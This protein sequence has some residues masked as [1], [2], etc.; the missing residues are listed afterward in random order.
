[1]VAEAKAISPGYRSS[2]LKA[3]SLASTLP[4]LDF[5]TAVAAK[6][7]SNAFF[8]RPYMGKFCPR[9]DVLAGPYHIPH[10]EILAL[11]IQSSGNGF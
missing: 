1:M 6:V 5:P 10:A 8:T 3:I 2:G 9:F 4:S 11:P 7:E